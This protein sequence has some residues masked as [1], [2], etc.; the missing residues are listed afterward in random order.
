MP[1][2][3]RE[4]PAKLVGGS[5]TKADNP[6]GHLRG[7]VTVEFTV[8]QSGAPS[9][10][11]TVAGDPSIGARTCGLVLQRLRFAPALDAQGRSV[12]SVT[13]ATYTWGQ[14]H[15]PLLRTLFGWIR[16]ARRPR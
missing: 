14:T 7:T 13:R 8:G 2:V 10:C 3:S 4:A 9:G 12:S 5:L 16:P 11:K 1:V 6:R 15:R